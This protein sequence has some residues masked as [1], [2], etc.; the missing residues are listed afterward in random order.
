[1]ASA[2]PPFP[3]CPPAYGLWALDRELEIFALDA[4]CHRLQACLD[5]QRLTFNQEDHLKRLRHVARDLRLQR[6]LALDQAAKERGI[7]RRARAK[8]KVPTARATGVAIGPPGQATAPSLRLYLDLVVAE[9]ASPRASTSI[10]AFCWRLDAQQILV[11]LCRSPSGQAGEATT[12]L[13]RAAQLSNLRL[14][15]ARQWE[16]YHPS[17]PQLSTS[18]RKWSCLVDQCMVEHHLALVALYRSTGPPLP[19]LSLPLPLVLQQWLLTRGLS[20]DQ[21]KAKTSA[22]KL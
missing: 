14:V 4:L 16:I 19:A 8:I 2:D 18:D 13:L 22:N 15:A 1:M 21:A 11:R 17:Q 7:V 6:R 10:P 12:S 9:S 20:F 3:S 5:E